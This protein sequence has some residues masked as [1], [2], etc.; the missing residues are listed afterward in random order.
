[1]Q[2]ARIVL[3]MDGTY[4]NKYNTLARTRGRAGGRAAQTS[5]ANDTTNV[6]RL[7]EKLVPSGSYNGK[8]YDIVRPFYIEGIGTISGSDDS[9][10][11]A[12]TGQGETGVLAKVERAVTLALE[13]LRSRPA[14][15]PFEFIHFDTFGFSRGAAAARNAIHRVLNGRVIPAGRSVIQLPSVRR[16]L[17]GRGFTIS[18]LKFR[19]SG[20]FDTVASYGAL[21]HRDDT[22]ELRLDAISSV[23]QVVHLAAAD[24]HRKNFRLTNTAAKRGGNSFELFL[25][26]GHSDI[27]G[28][29]NAGATG[30][31]VLWS[32]SVMRGFSTTAVEQRMNAELAWLSGQGWFTGPGNYLRG[33]NVVVGLQRIFYV[34]GRQV[35]PTNQYT[36]IPLNIMGRRAGEQAL[37]FSGLQQVTNAELVRV[38]AALRRYEN[39]RRHSSQP[40]DWFNRTTTSY[41]SDLPGLRARHL[42]FTSFLQDLSQ[43]VTIGSA[44]IDGLA[45]PMGPEY[46]GGR[47]ARIIQRG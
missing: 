1:M 32:E 47:R 23:D 20:L 42:H 25:P 40:S 11:G 7:S 9:T 46:V 19:F 29:Y 4:N 39:E 27:G 30:H 28:G 33:S 45:A 17:T 22:S 2:N 18:E 10:Y 6:A 37:T 41:I 5:Y 24:E 36:Y 14:G 38:E 12:A 31:Y 26:G 34:A 15:I 35:T 44:L 8:A 13:L 3:F 16:D 21:V 43:E